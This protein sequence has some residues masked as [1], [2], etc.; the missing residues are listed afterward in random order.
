MN[1]F[2]KFASFAA[3]GAALALFLSATAPASAAPYAVD[4]PQNW[5]AIV[6]DRFEMDKAAGVELGCYP[7]ICKDHGGYDFSKKMEHHEA[8]DRKCLELARE[9]CAFWPQRDKASCLINDPIEALP[10]VPAFL[11][12]ERREY[13]NADGTLNH[14]GHLLRLRSSLGDD[15]PADATVH[16][17]K[18][19]NG[20]PQP[21]AFE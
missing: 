12:L 13:I 14:A 19:L 16:V 2:R 4:L 20:R 17:I 15:V 21:C 5:I 10:S 9:G 3:I 8:G 11:I 18:V 7:S 1:H 6:G